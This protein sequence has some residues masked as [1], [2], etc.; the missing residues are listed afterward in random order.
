MSNIKPFTPDL[1]SQWA[2]KLMDSVVIRK[3]KF[4][5]SLVEPR[6]L[7]LVRKEK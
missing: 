5:W 2:R 1:H 3:D 6:M 4:K 7:K